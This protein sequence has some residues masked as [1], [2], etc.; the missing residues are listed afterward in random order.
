MSGAIWKDKLMVSL[1]SG[2]GGKPPGSPLQSSGFGCQSRAQIVHPRPGAVLGEEGGDPPGV[3]W[4]AI[5]GLGS[6]SW[7]IGC[8]PG[9]SE[10]LRLCA[11]PG[12]VLR[13]GASLFITG[14]VILKAG[15]NFHR[16]AG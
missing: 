14:R 3:S 9:F 10:P 6:S 7:L 4:L 1:G 13:D 12:G 16:A 2:R 8:L 11:V 15:A 5:W